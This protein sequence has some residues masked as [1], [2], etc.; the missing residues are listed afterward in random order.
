MT[1][2]EEITGEDVIGLPG[3]AL[4]CA[5]LAALV[6]LA[7]GLPNRVLAAN[8]GMS[9]SAL[10]VVEHSLQAK[11]GAKNKPHMITRGFALGVL[12][13]RALAVL[14]CL[15]AV[16]EADHDLLR[17]RFNRRP[18][19]VV[20]VARMVKTAPSTSGGRPLLAA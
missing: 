8:M 15:A 2:F 17:Q 10:R 12:V 13:P 1:A 3:Q 16:L 14:L 5:E 20:E 6:G 11:L 4:S 18:R 9:E 19:N 7:D